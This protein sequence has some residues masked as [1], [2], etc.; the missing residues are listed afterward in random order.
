MKSSAKDLKLVFVTRVSNLPSKSLGFGSNILE[1][2]THD[3]RFFGAMGM[4]KNEFN[5]DDSKP[6]NNGFGRLLWC[7]LS[8]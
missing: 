3:E 5:H 1:D 4:T 8:N 6:F 7:I 2:V